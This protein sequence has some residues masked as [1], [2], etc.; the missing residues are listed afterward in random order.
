MIDW[1]LE[2]CETILWEGRPSLLRIDPIGVIVWG[3]ISY[4]LVISM[5]HGY[6]LLTNAPSSWQSVAYTSML[7]LSTLVTAAFVASLPAQYLSSRYCL[8][9]RRLLKLSSLRR[10]IIWMP[11][12]PRTAVTTKGLGTLRVGESARRTGDSRLSDRNEL[13]SNPVK[14]ILMYGLWGRGSVCSLIENVKRGTV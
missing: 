12:G 10:K 14:C 9:N 5:A 7:V 1:S 4:L 8:T 3:A 6:E 2:T 11:I 13:I